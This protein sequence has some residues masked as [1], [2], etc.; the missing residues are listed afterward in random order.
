VDSAWEQEKLEARKM[1]EKPHRTL[2][3]SASMKMGESHHFVRKDGGLYKMQSQIAGFHI[4]SA[5]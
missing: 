3:S 2:A 4:K 1:L 5:I